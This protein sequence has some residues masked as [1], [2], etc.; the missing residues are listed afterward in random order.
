MM[1]GDDFHDVKN[2]NAAKNADNDEYDDILPDTNID[3]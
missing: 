2:G 3:R 1:Y